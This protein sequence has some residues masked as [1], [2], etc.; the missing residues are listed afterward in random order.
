MSIEELRS[1]INGIYSLFVIIT[2]LQLSFPDNNPSEMRVISVII[3]VFV[4]QNLLSSYG[5]RVMNMAIFFIANAERV[6]VR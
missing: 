2:Y 1:S 3:F 6:S 4:V 5:T